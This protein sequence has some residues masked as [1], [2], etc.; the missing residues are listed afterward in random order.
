MDNQRYKKD[1]KK[2]K[3]WAYAYY[4][5]DD[6]IATDEEYDKLY[7]KILNY[8]RLNPNKI[9]KNSPTQMVG[10]VVRNGF[11]KAKHIEKMWSMED[12]F[13]KD[14]VLQWINRIVKNIGK[15]VYLCEPKFDGA[16]MNLLYDKGKL[17]SAI[18]RGDGE[19]G[20]EVIDNVKTISSIPWYINYQGLIEIRGEVVIPKDDFEKIN[21]KRLKKEGKLF[22]NPRNMASGSLRQLDSSITAKRYLAFYPWG[23]GKNSLNLPLLSQ[24]MEFIYNLGFLSLPYSTKCEDVDEIERFYRFLIS[25]RDEIPITMDGMVIKVDNIK[26]EELLG[27]TVKYPKWMSAYKFPAVEKVTRVNSITLQVGRTGV[28]TPIAEVKAVAINGAIVKRATLHNFDEIERKG[29]K[30]GDWVILIR[31]GDVIPKITKVLTDRRNGKEKSILRP[32]RCPTCGSKLLDNGT[33]I[34]C[35]NLNCPDRIINSIIHFT[36]KGCMDIA[37]VGSKMVELLV[38]EN[39][40]RSILDLYSLKVEDLEKLKG[41]QRKKAENTINAINNSRK[42]ALKNFINGLG[43]E[44]IGKVASKYIALEFGLDFVNATKEQLIKVD[45]VGQETADSFV[46]FI[47]INRDSVLK[48]L[49]IINPTVEER[50]KAKDTLFKDKIVV[51]TGAMSESRAKIVEKL[52]ALG[53]KVTTSVS[54]KTDYLI[55]GKDVGSKYQ[56]AKELN[57]KTLAEDDIR[58]YL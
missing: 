3:E 21:Q 53:A 8:E 14:E 50:V 30:L 10:S 18:T 52:T 33:L 49:K 24:K 41:F 57:I 51:L 46:E 35:Q 45:G 31:S 32:I 34:K 26:K 38:K 4:V 29:L 11:K 28:I 25:K 5:E 47:R 54:G 58:E 19:I 55:Y 36:K 13:T 27:Y 48:L 42:K 6:P 23:V 43:I 39:K 37:G 15:V 1:I 44:H 22:A 17:I 16:S 40:I 7:H 2:L 12:L 9:D 56:K 20:E